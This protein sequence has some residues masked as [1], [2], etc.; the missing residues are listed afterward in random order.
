MPK[1]TLIGCGWFG[2]PFAKSLLKQG[3]H[4][5]ANKRLAQDITPLNDIGIDGFQLDL[6]DV[7]CIEPKH[8]S[9]IEQHFDS[10]FLVINI[11]PG[12][13]RKESQYLDNLLRLKQIIADK[14]YQRLIFISSTGVYPSQNKAVDESDAQAFNLVSQTLLQAEAIFSQ[15]HNAT[16]V[17]FAGLIGP[18]RHPG[19]FFAGKNDVAG[20][21]MA[22]NLVHL[23]DCIAAVTLIMQSDNAR[24]IYNLCAPIHPTKS[25]FYTKACEHLGVALPTFNEES[26]A[27]KT[28]LAERIVSQLGFNYQF[29]DPVKMLDAC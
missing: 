22:V 29:Q 25:V 16:V 10:D 7:D 18:K 3:F 4:V 23:E 11:P 13:R 24:G 21:Q 8:I 19:R 20:G 14:Q 9:A 27:D 17:R 5:S 15:M 2:L 6:A 1:V 12:L 26:V 28:I